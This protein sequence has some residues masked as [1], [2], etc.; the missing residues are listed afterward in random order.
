VTEG[1]VGLTGSCFYHQ[2]LK[3]DAKKFFLS[4]LSFREVA[5]SDFFFVAP[6]LLCSV[7]RLNPFASATI[8]TMSSR[9]HEQLIEQDPVG[10]ETR[11]QTE[12]QDDAAL[13]V[14]AAIG[15]IRDKC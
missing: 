3:Q 14:R 13:L 9:Q 2:T 11:S 15:R 6:H 5:L 4:S 1:G 12:S 7:D 8:G 10:E